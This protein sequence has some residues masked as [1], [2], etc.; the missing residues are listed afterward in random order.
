MLAQWF[1]NGI[2]LAALAAAVWYA[3]E[4]RKLRLQMIR[5]KLFFF[6]RQHRP[7]T[8]DDRKSVDLFIKNIGD[9]AAINVSIEK[10]KE[11]QFEV[12]ADP[13]HIPVLEKGGEVGLAIRPAKGP[14]TPDM[15]IILDDA[16]I[17][18]RLTARY[19]DVE[20]REFRTST[21]VGAGAK[22]PLIRELRS[23]KSLHLGSEFQ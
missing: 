22:P 6:T 19:V 8:P 20:S 14:Y 1:G 12:R 17:S 18:V 16:S 21:A 9:G 10:T 15:S 11:G 13:E 7:E 3:W 5:P 2:L 4:T 23:S